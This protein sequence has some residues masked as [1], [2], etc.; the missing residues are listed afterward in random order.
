MY[1]KGFKSR[2][3][4]IL[5]CLIFTVVIFFAMSKSP[6]SKTVE[7]KSIDLKAVVI[8]AGDG[9]MWKD[10]YEQLEQSLLANISIIAI[11]IGKEE[12]DLS[13]YDVIY[14]DGSINT[15]SNKE[16]I[17]DDLI[18]FTR[19]G[20]GLFLENEFWD[21]F[22][23]DFIGAGEF[24]KLTG[25][26]K[27]LEFPEVRHNLM[28]IQEIIKDFDYIYKDY[29]DYE[30][31]DTYDYGYGVKDATGTVLAEE[32]GIALYTINKVGDGYVFFTNPLLPNKFNING[33]SMIAT[34]DLQKYFANTTSSSNQLIK[35][36]FAAFVSKDRYGFSVER[37]LGNY[38]RPSMAWQLHYEEITGFENNSA[39]IFAEIA[40]ENLQIPSFTIIRNSYNWFHRFEVVSYLL[41]D[42]EDEKLN[43]T[44]DEYENAY[45]SGRHIVSDGK[46]LSLEVIENGG[47]YF[48]D[49]PEYDLRAYPFATDFNNDGV[50]DLLSGS[51]DGYF[52]FFQGEEMS[53]NFETSKG[54]KLTNYEGKLIS[55][56]GYS[57]P[58]MLDINGD[59]FIDLISGSSDGNIYWFSGNGDM[60]FEEEGILVNVWD[61]DQCLP[62]VGD[63]NND[64]IV[65]L[66]VGGNKKQMKFYYGNK[67]GE[68]LEFTTSIDTQIIGLE[69]I[70][71]EWI[72]PYVID[73]ND[74]GINDIV[75]GTFNGYIAKFIGNGESYIFDGYMEGKEKNYK[76][77]KNLKF[78]NNSVPTFGDLNNDG[79]LD[80]IVGSF[81][82]GL[83]YPIDS[84]YFPMKDKLSDQIKFMKDNGYYVG[85]HF[86]TNVGAS[87][88]YE[89]N[90]LAMHLAALEEYGV[91]TL[92]P[93]GFNQHTWHTSKESQTQSLENGFQAGLLWNSGFKPSASNA[94][95]ESSAETA[96]N[97]P[98][99]FQDGKVNKSIIFNTSTMLY[100]SKGW[101]DIS[102]KYDLPV[103]MYYHCDFAYSNLEKIQS[104]VMKAAT[105]A[106]K[107]DYNFVTE[108]QYVKAIAASYNTKFSI[109]VGNS[110]SKGDIFITKQTKDK[111]IPLYDE[112]YQ[113]SVGVKI[114]L[115]EKHLGKTV[116]TSSTIWVQTD[117][118]IYVGTDGNISLNFGKPKEFHLTRANLPVDVNYTAN[119]AKIEFKV[120]GMMQVEV[121]GD[122]TT[123]DEGWIITKSEN[124]NAT[125]LT[126]FG[127]AETLNI[128]K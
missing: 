38:G 118:V 53:D 106:R 11:D 73:I 56:P 2:N 29:I 12:Y 32:N 75:V 97:I 57:A 80:L 35:N 91:N 31:L 104:D 24:V 107:Y 34:N 101:G 94:T 36:Q 27:Q 126:K 7:S 18:R 70:E 72:S 109:N 83:A 128:K 22:N 13:L 51:K 102:A 10:T 26:P 39:K 115:G 3:I 112:D 23:K 84:K 124:R 79:K 122:V 55:V 117:N 108:D 69:D 127:L 120:G 125:I 63:I 25:A 5:I 105:F 37:V 88:E 61:T 98:F 65:D 42:R 1:S 76:E 15:V 68:N 96:L 86:Y 114:V 54:I 46:W 47:S 123:T 45:S 121:S 81:E 44:M 14:L 50:L 92:E 28:G 30:L 40:K 58:A 119:G 62:S 110:E 116:D 77:N 43:Y 95:P 16:V 6:S 60:T 66:V 17:K 103:S 9:R 67:N 33:L 85:I 90:E 59:K 78:G 99:C 48:V 111:T 113:N 41:N 71:G 19:E 20:G 82:Y 74:D 49:Y 52:H 21:F 8:Y 87:D 64:G 4:I 93:R 100:D 89:E